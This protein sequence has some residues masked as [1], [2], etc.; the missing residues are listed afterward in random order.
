MLFRSAGSDYI[1]EATTAALTLEQIDSISA[2]IDALDQSLDSPLFLGG[3]YFLGGT[4]STKVITYTGSYL[5]GNIQTGDIGS[6]R[7][8]ITLIRPQIDNGSASVAV[9]SRQQLDDD[10][11]Y[12]TAVSA[13][14]ENR[15]S[16]RSGGNYHRIQIVPT[17]NNW[18]NAIAVDV[19]VIGQGVR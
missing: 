7:S 12:G 4:L 11:S 5:T 1:S 15:V 17:G 13:S 16:L 18:K 3:K 19:E 6:Q 14:S 9:A 8:V 10:I 2:S